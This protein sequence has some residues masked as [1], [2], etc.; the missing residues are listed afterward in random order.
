MFMI[1]FEIQTQWTNILFQ[2]KEIEFEEYT[3]NVL[4]SQ[5]IK[6]IAIPSFHAIGI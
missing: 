4:D 5:S 6:N 3:P 2:I 1:L